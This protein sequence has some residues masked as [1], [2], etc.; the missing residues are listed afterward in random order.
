MRKAIEAFARSEWESA[1]EFAPCSTQSAFLADQCG[2]WEVSS[3]HEIFEG[4]FRAAPVPTLAVHF[5]SDE[6]ETVVI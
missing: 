4:I 2:R 3:G 5:A 6:L 1:A